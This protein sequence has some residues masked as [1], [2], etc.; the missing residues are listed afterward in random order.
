MA[1]GTMAYA[2]HLDLESRIADQLAPSISYLESLGS[3]VE[4]SRRLGD[5]SHMSLG[6]YESFKAADVLPRI[7][8]FVS[9]IRPFGS[10]LSSIGVFPGETSVLFLAPVAT[11]ELLDLH[12]RFH[13]TFADHRSVCWPHY[14]PGAWVPHVTLAM[15]LDRSVLPAAMA[16]VSRTWEP[17]DARFTALRVVQFRPV[18]VICIKSL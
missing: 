15:N 12:E 16:E 9:T 10:R 1:G 6:I 3:T 11:Q 17:I 18:Q 13:A 2:V 8:T 7:D 4:T 5:V 14:R